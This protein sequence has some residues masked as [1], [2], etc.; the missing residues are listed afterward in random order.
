MKMRLYLLTLMLVLASS[1]AFAQSDTLVITLKNKQVEKIAIT[2]IRKVQFENITGVEEQI[3]PKSIE[4]K[5]N[6]PNPFTEQTQIEFEIASP[7]DVSIIIYDV[8]GKQIRT[9]ECT[10][11]QAG[12]NTLTWDCLDMNYR[13]VQ[14][15]TYYYEVRFGSEVKAKNMILV[16]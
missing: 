4:A 10:G 9:L 15:G 7:G 3:T 1:I 8:T 13:R 6:Y 2:D 5:G 11:C 14:S 16:K 12:K